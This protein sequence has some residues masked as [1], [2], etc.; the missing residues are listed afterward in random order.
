MARYQ[1]FV[2]CRPDTDS[3]RCCDDARPAIDSVRSKAPGVKG[4]AAQPTSTALIAN[5]SCVSPHCGATVVG[6]RKY[7]LNRFVNALFSSCW[8]LWDH[9]AAPIAALLLCGSRASGYP[10]LFSV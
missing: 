9:P 7:D 1:V 6:V 5:E 3:R 8:G 4:R 10:T 2:R